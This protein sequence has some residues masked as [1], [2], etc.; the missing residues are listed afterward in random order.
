MYVNRKIRDV[1]VVIRLCAKRSNGPPSIEAGIEH[2]LYCSVR[3]DPYPL[4]SSLSRK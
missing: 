1:K 2:T 3:M 4:H